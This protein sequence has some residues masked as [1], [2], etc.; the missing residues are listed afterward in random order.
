MKKLLS[1]IFIFSTFH[2]LAQKSLLLLKTGSSIKPDIEKVARDYYDHFDNIKGE[3]ISESES[4]IEYQ[5]KII[6]AGSLESTITQIKSLHNVYSWQTTLLKTDDYEKA[7]EKY[8]QIFHQLNGSNFKIQENQ[9]WKFE[10]LYD[11]P[12]DARSFASS[13]L[14]P[15]VSDKVFQR[16]KIEIALNYNMP[17]WTVKVMVYEKENDADIRPSEKTGSF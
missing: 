3:K 6:P 7:V 15:N 2:L 5:S 16:L 11:T 8:K 12:D 14:E 1:L 10:G 4:T 13:I 17:N 9:S